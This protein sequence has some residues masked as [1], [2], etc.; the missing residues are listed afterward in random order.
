MK[1]LF[2]V[3]AKGD[4]SVTTIMA[5]SIDEAFKIF[6]KHRGLD[7]VYPTVYAETNMQDI[8]IKQVV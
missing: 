8:N 2:N 7:G 3:Y 1:Y 6:C 4:F 5:N